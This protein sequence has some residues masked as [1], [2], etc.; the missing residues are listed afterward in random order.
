[1]SEIKKFKESDGEFIP[2]SQADE[3]FRDTKDAYKAAGVKTLD[4]THSQFFG[5]EK[6]E[7]L[8][9]HTGDQ[10]VGLKFGFTLDDGKLNELSLTVQ[11]VDSKGNVLNVLRGSNPAAGNTLYAGPRCPPTCI[12]PIPPDN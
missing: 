1:M 3:L 8:L 9:H 7:E 6:L 11:A 10:C 4:Y 12:P 5:R 2:S